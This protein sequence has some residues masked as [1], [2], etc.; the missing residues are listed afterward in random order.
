MPRVRDRLQFDPIHGAV[1]DGP[2]RYLLMRHDVLMGMIAALP[3][4][5]RPTVL[6][7]MA[8]SVAV[9]GADS[10]RAY[11]AA[12]SGD[13]EAL[14]EATVEAA[15]DLGWGRWEPDGTRLWVENSPFVSGY[16]PSDSPVCAP[17]GGLWRALSTIVSGRPMVVQEIHCAAQ[18]HTC[19]EF[20]AI[21]VEFR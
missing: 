14:L 1:T 19:C 13:T 11:L 16:G 15:A 2:R 7:A 4:A 5:L 18:G 9:H 12:S 6:A 8:D 21:P 17:I 10:L 3:H 20:M